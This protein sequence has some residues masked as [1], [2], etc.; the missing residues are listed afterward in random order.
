MAQADRLCKCNSTI[1][2]L[3]SLK[4]R[5]GVFDLLLIYLIIFQTVAARGTQDV[6]ARVACC[7]CSR[8][9]KRK[10]LCADA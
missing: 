5:I 10:V 3:P 2:T 4:T 7:V 6:C 9:R 1:H 8:L